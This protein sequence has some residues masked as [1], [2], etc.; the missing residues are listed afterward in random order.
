M[1]DYKPLQELPLYNTD[2]HRR[3]MIINRLTNYLCIVKT[4]TENS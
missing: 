4:D 2:G 3:Y 1:R